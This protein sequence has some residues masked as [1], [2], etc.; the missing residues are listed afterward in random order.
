MKF[1][2]TTQL[3]V[4]L[5]S[6]V[7]LGAAKSAAQSESFHVQGTVTDLNEGVI[8]GAKVSFHSNQTTK[9]ASTNAKGVYEAD[10]ELGV[11]TM[12]VQYPRFHLFHRPAFRI[13]SPTR[14]TFNAALLVAGSCDVV[15]SNSS[16]APPTADELDEGV[17]LFCT[18][19]ESFPVPSADGVP[20]EVY[21]HYGNRTAVNGTY[22]YTSQ[23]HLAPQV[24][25][26]YNLFSLLADNVVYDAAH[27]TLEARGHVVATEET[28]TERADS[29]SFKVENGKAIPLR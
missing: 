29:M 3:V 24:F 28:A 12:T 21:V 10:L 19:E 20:F 2:I 22:T 27:R 16:G 9:E 26:A 11:Y 1:S 25:V 5:C 6:H 8:P 23:K 4:L 13:T 18:R 7:V 15:V 17:R 14:V